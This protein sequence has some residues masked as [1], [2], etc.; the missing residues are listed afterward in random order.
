M[1][2]LLQQWHQPRVEGIVPQPV[3]EVVVMKT[4]AE[5]KR[6]E[7][8]QCKLYE[9][10]KQQQ[11]NVVQFLDTV[12]GIDSTFGLV[13]TCEVDESASKVPT[14]FG[15]SPAGSFGSYQLSFQESNFTVTSSFEPSSSSHTDTIPNYP[16]FPLDDLNDD[17]ILPV[18]E[19]LDNSQKKILDSLTVSLL[20]A[21]KLE[22]ETR[23]QS[24]SDK[25]V[26]A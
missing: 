10:R 11:S 13:Q 16:S 9:A 8:V 12:R 23:E 25:W 15:S 2:T 5:E 24:S 20:N 4:H 17:Y 26:Q 19:G 3:M 6:T 7:G 21:N 1:K 22:Q 18:P 14:K